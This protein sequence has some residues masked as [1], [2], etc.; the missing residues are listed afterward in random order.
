M[1]ADYDFGDLAAKEGS[2]DSD[3]DGLPDRFENNEQW[4]YKQMGWENGAGDLSPDNIKGDL[5]GLETGA[6]RDF[7]ENID[8][9]ASWNGDFGSR[10]KRETGDSETEEEASNVPS[11]MESG[12]SA[13]GWL[14]AAVRKTRN[15]EPGN[16]NGNKKPQKGKQRTQKRKGN[17][18]TQK[19]K[20]KKRN[21][22]KKRRGGKGRRGGNKKGKGRS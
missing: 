13:L 4:F 15:A 22:R 9:C 19:K 12:S 3:N 21:A 16:G 11:V 2:K 17:K 8:K 6:K 10:R 14:K 20:G 7:D 5:A 1:G 18:G